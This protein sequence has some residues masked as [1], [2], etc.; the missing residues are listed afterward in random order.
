MLTKRTSEG[1]HSPNTQVNAGPVLSQP[2]L[3][4]C[5]CNFVRPCTSVLTHLISILIYVRWTAIISPA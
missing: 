5:L 4:S 1:Q 2:G 3:R